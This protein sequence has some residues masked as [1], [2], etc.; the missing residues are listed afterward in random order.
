[1]SSAERAPAAQPFF[2]DTTKGKRF[3]LYRAPS[4]SQACAGAILYVHPF[5]DEMNMSRRMAAQQSRAF[6][7]AGFGVLQIDLYGCGDSEGELKDADWG[8]WKQDLLSAA[9][10][11]RAHVSDS[12]TLWGL[13]LGALLALDTALDGSIDANRCIL[14]QPV[15][16][17]RP[18]MTQF[19]RLGLAAGLVATSETGGE[20]QSPRDTLAR[21]ETTEVGGYELTPA[22]V[23]DI[24]GIDLSGLQQASF[25]IH[26]FELVPDDQA[27]VLAARMNM[28]RAWTDRQIDLRLHAVTGPSFW[29]TKEIAEAPG[30]ISETTGLFIE[31]PA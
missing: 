2:L 17:G 31:E 13:R 24:D 7:A 11:L 8:T 20:R 3:C 14:W 25:P 21:G 29:A 4:P 10:W 28:A 12:V 27:L 18:Y 6:A 19:L 15:F 30:L 9:Q 26:W 16:A 23:R 22:L 5:G 1:M